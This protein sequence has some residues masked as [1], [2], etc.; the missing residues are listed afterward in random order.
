M[1]EVLK[2]FIG[3]FVIIY[4][5][6]NFIFNQTKEEHLRHVRYVIERL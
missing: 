1:D 3:K 4:L 5:D 2:E 6:D